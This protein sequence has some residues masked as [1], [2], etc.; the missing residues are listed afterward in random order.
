MNIEIRDSALEAR[1][2][3]QIQAT[4]AASAEEALLHLLETQEE[5]DRW[6]LEN[7][8]AINAKIRRGIAQLDRGEGVHEEELD[9]YLTNLKAQPE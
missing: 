5:Q 4:G 3:R 9:A 8:A 6:L 2:Q 7:K 1:I